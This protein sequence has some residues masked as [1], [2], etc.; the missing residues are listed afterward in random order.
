MSHLQ[1]PGDALLTRAHGGRHKNRCFAIWTREFP[2]ASCKQTGTRRKLT[3]RSAACNVPMPARQSTNCVENAQIKMH[4]AN[5]LSQVQVLPVR[6]CLVDPATVAFKMYASKSAAAATCCRFHNIFLC[7]YYFHLPLF[8]A[9]NLRFTNIFFSSSFTHLC[10]LRSD[11][12]FVWILVSF[13][14]VRLQQSV[15][16]AMRHKNFTV[17][18]LRTVFIY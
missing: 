2:G 10:R 4:A 15:A 17:Y 8:N 7:L 14:K 16:F 18:K 13:A 11:C 3:R 12:L 5:Y 6:W 9:C 1:H